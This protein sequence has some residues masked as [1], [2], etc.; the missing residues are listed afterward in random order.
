MHKEGAAQAAVLGQA[1]RTACAL[2]LIKILARTPKSTPRA[3]VN[4]RGFQIFSHLILFWLRKRCFF[5]HNPRQ[6]FGCTSK[7]RW[8]LNYILTYRLAVNPYPTFFAVQQNKSYLAKLH[9]I[10]R[11]WNSGLTSDYGSKKIFYEIEKNRKLKKSLNVE[12]LIIP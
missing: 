8:L 5:K 10:S 7:A 9:C 12:D 1:G 11:M 3:P 2:L 4:N 6:V